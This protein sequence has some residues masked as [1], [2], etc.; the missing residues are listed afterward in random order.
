MRNASR[1]GSRSLQ[2]YYCIYTINTRL[3]CYYDYYTIILLYFRHKG[4]PVAQAAEA[5]RLALR[6][7]QL[8]QFAELLR[9]TLCSGLNYT[10]LLRQL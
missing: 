10:I 9:P 8:A 2:S 1:Y 4:P 6:I 3:L 7:A 5:E